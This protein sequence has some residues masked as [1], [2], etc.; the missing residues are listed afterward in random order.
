VTGFLLLAIAFLW[1]GGH[2]VLF[3]VLRKRFGSTE[4]AILKFQVASFCALVGICLAVLLISADVSFTGAV[5]A[6]AI[7][8]IYSLSFLELW[9]LA[10]GGYSLQLLS[11]LDSG[12]VSRSS[13]IDFVAEIGDAKREARIRSLKAAGLITTSD[14]QL[15]LTGRGRLAAGAVAVLR[16]IAGFREPG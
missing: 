16:K 14:R 15:N 13:V 5:G 4:G 12:P 8:G 3:V 6:I 11:A 1:C 2:L 7:H 9:S 10:E